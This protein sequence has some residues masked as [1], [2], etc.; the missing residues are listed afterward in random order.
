ML[1]YNGAVSAGS[2][3]ALGES[4]DF[5]QGTTITMKVLANRSVPVLFKLEGLN[6][7]VTQTY[8]G[9]GDWEQ[10]SFDF[11]AVAAAGAS[12]VT[13]IFDLGVAGDAAGDP[14][15]WT[16]YFDDIQIAN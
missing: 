5:S 3:L 9:S 14:D 4:I 10:L 2:T 8:T 6:V 12:A 11:S 1:K 16:F 13:L 15:N 7:E